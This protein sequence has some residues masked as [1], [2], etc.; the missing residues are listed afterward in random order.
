MSNNITQ[1]DTP[2]IALAKR[3]LARHSK[4]F[5]LRFCRQMRFWQFVELI[6]VYLQ[7]C[8]EVCCTSWFLVPQKMSVVLNLKPR[9]NSCW[10]ISDKYKG[11][12]IRICSMDIHLVATLCRIRPA[13]WF[14]AGTTS[15]FLLMCILSRCIPYD[16][17]L[18]ISSSRFSAATSLENDFSGNLRLGQWAGWSCVSYHVYELC[19]SCSANIASLPAFEIICL[20]YGEGGDIISPAF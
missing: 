12:A 4:D 14:I 11:V 9:E 13:E 10:Q 6:Q 18:T 2:Y 7:L 15:W 3:K 17:A 5:K 20:G 1:S 19:Y 8:S 16:C